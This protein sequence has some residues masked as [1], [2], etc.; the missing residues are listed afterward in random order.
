[1]ED[2]EK[3]YKEVLDQ[4]NRLSRQQPAHEESQRLFSE[5]FQLNENRIEAL[6]QS[7][8]LFRNTFEQAAVGIVY[9]TLKGGFIRINKRFCEMLG[10]SL[11]DLLTLNIQE[12]TY[13]DDF[14]IDQALIR[15]LVEKRRDAF[16]RDKRYIR[17]D[18]SLM[19]ARLTVSLVLGDSGEP[20][21][22]MAVIEDVSQRMKTEEKFKQSEERNRA[23]LTLI[24]DLVFRIDMRGTYL[25]YKA[26]QEELAIPADQII[27]NNI[28]NLEVPSEFKEN[29]MQLISKAIETNNMQFYE[30]QLEVMTGLQSY[31]ARIVK[32]GEDEVVCIVRNITE[33]KLA[34]EKTRELEVQ[35][36][37]AQKMEAVGTLAGGI[38]HDFNNILSAIMGY[39]ELAE[40][41]IPHDSPGKDH[42]EGILEAA[43]RAK[44]LV[45]QIL[46]FSRQSELKLTPMRLNPLVK[47]ALKLLRASL[48]STIRFQVD[49]DSECG[50]V[51][52]DPVQIHQVMMNLCT[53][54]S[55]VMK[56]TT[57]LLEVSIKRV[58]VSADFAE[59]FPRLSPGDY[60]KLT[61]KDNGPGMEPAVLDRI[62]EP[63]FTT[64]EKG[65][66]TGLGLSVVHGI[67]NRH[68][69]E[70]VVISEPGKGT[71]FD[72]YFPIIPS[73]LQVQT[74]KN[75]QTLQ[76][77]K[78]KEHILLIDD[79]KTLA[80]MNKAMLTRLGYTATVTAD[81][82]EALELFRQEPGKF[83]MVITDMTMP[84]MTGDAL[85]KELLDLRPG[86]PIILCTGYTDLVTPAE[87][88]QMGIKSYLIKPI[89]MRT[90]AATIR[91]LLDR[92]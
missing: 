65:E 14:A 18:G 88:K 70:I 42:I 62:F 58:P 51:N 36:H 31:E 41:D 72:V 30:Y 29:V 87:A 7:E 55:Y 34:E 33:R 75:F 92:S 24:P 40:M 90:L 44:E 60:A 79:E 54:A 73:S 39:T 64:K 83:D 4:L 6:K 81:S 52:S 59:K 35:L 89:S 23:L 53:N 69:G 50:E 19:W 25:D 71:T 12:I 61:V 32:S 47:E 8:L 9:A 63:Y 45:R 28:M 26:P 22:L 49:I 77:G 27:G 5:L 67:V 91:N 10:Y 1:M 82:L 16:S 38:A 15:E 66:G 13:R 80:D 37:Q 20:K 78:E 11:E 86:I 74:V 84:T 56:P 57:G 43:N 2:K 76:R 68:K 85:A 21:Y 17:K 46:A 3:R 48:P